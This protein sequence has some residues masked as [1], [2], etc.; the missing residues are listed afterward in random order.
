MTKR[1]TEAKRPERVA[2]PLKDRPELRGK[3][4]REREAKPCYLPFSIAT[5]CA[6]CFEDRHGISPFRACK[7]RPGKTEQAMIFIMLCQAIALFGCMYQ[8]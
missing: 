1:R 6:G 3:R 8:I 2:T 4:E 5:A 7:L